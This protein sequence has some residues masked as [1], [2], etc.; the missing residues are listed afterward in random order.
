[1]MSLIVLFFLLKIS[2]YSMLH[3]CWII[4]VYFI[5]LYVIHQGLLEHV[6]SDIKGSVFEVKSEVETLRKEIDDVPTYVAFKTG[7][8]IDKIPG[9]MANAYPPRDFLRK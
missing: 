8:Q 6:I 3:F 2:G 9:M 7:D 5:R 4:P 1:M